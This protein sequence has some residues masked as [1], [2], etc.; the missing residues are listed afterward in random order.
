MPTFLAIKPFKPSTANHTMNC[1]SL[2]LF[3]LAI[4]GVRS[5][6]ALAQAKCRSLHHVDVDSSGTQYSNQKCLLLCSIHGKV[7]PHNMSEGLPCPALLGSKNVCQ[8]GQ[9]VAPLK[10]GYIDIEMTSASLAKKATGWSQVVLP[11]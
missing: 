2:A 8:N 9:C 3:T 5:D 4:V 10:L 11:L 1:F 7:W 6:D